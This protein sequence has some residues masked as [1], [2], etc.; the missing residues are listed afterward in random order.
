MKQTISL[1][2]WAT[3]AVIL[4]FALGLKMTGTYPYPFLLD[5]H[6]MHQQIAGLFHHQQPPSVW[7]QLWLR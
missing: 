5:R 3:T 2:T 1:Y 7:E 4:A 6:D